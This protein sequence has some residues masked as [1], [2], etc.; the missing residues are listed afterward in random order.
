MSAFTKFITRVPETIFPE[1]RFQEIRATAP[2][3]KIYNIDATRD[4]VKN[5]PAIL[6]PFA[7]AAAATMSIPYDVTQGIMRARDKF[8]DANPTSFGIDDYGE[9]P[10]GPSFSDVAAAI[11]AENPISSAIERTKGATFGLA[12][13]L[14]RIP[15]FFNNLIFTPLGADSERP[16]P[17]EDDLME[18][19]EF[20]DMPEEKKREGILQA[21]LSKGKDI[22]GNISDK[23]PSFGIMG[24]LSK[25][26]NFK[27]LSPLDRQFILE[28]AGGNRPAKDRYG[29]NIRSALGNYADLVSRRAQIARNRALFK[30]PLRAI[31]LYYQKKEA[32]RAAK[33]R[34]ILDAEFA[35]GRGGSGQDFTG[36]RYDGAPDAATYSAEPTAYSGSS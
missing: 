19:D 20:Y 26:D 5:Q 17:I 24:L 29:Y 15:G 3:Q 2:S 18:Y 21:I 28:Q 32:E 11:D 13:Q 30:Q 8:F 7:P 1:G 25:L 35:A 34:A 12:D 27:N 10:I 4:L 36:G 33:D 9:V 23:I 31:D 6:A 14:A 22:V 16:A